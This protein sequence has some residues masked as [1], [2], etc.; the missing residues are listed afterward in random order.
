MD[1]QNF[2]KLAGDY[3][4][5]PVYRT[6]MG[7]VLTPVSLFLKLR[8]N[9]RYPF[10]LES[11][12]GGETLARYSFLGRNPYQVLHYDGDRVTLTSDG[13]TADLGTDYF[14]SLKELTTAYDEPD[15]A[16]LPRLTGGAVGFSSYDTVREVEHLPDVPEDDLQLPEAIWAFYDEI[17]AFDHVKQ[18]II[19]I[20]TVFPD[21]DRELK[22]IY[23]HAQESLDR[24]EALVEDMLALARQGTA[25]DETEP[26][27]L[28]S[29]AEACW[30]G[31]DTATA[32][33][34]VADD[35]RFR[36]DK[37]R[38]RQ[39]LENLFANAVAHAG[40]S[41]RVEVGVLPDGGGFYVEDDGPGIPDD[42]RDEVFDA[43]VTTDPDGTGFGL[44]I[45]AE[46]ADAHGWTL[47]LADAADAH[48]WTLDL[49]DAA[50]GGAR[51]EFRGVE[52]ADEAS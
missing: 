28:G 34:V 37:S 42:R 44:K 47:D 2:K 39:A 51:F 36:A 12:E 5:V 10:L 18:Q 26:V 9:T 49:A 40:E 41:V 4:A 22:E 19:I 20:K 11:V 16:D 7:D 14:A 6:L 35:F 33:F 13:E 27:S 24:M 30:E 1:F 50:D 3:S 29:L 48:G 21:G 38:L 46:V 23:R 52:P 31:V 43:G 17:F 25:I 45:V 32:E 8:E 15:I